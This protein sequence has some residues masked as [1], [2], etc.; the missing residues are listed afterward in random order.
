MNHPR[1]L[2][3]IVNRHGAPTEVLDEK[4]LNELS[5]SAPLNRTWSE[6]FAKNS[7]AKLP[8]KESRLSQ[9][10]ERSEKRRL[11]KKEKKFQL[12]KD[13][14]CYSELN[15]IDPHDAKKEFGDTLKLNPVG[16]AFLSAAATAGVKNGTESGS[17]D[18]HVTTVHNVVDGKG[19]LNYII[20]HVQC[21]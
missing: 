16:P 2:S 6:P 8:R 18:D 9:V 1:P 21:I 19:A 3:T 10:S 20:V 5:T 12:S 15:P 13:D 17:G 11:S 7:G 4:M 14:G